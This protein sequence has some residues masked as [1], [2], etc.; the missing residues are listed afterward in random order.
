MRT[1]RI[2][3]QVALAAAVLAA[4]VFGVGSVRTVTPP[5]QGQSLHKELHTFASIT[6]SSPIRVASFNMHSGRGASGKEDLALT[7]KTAQGFDLVGYQEV[8]ASPR[9]T[10]PPQ[11]GFIGQS[12]GQA[13]LFAPTERQYWGDRFGNG[14]TTN[15]PVQ[16]WHREPLPAP[17]EQSR[18]NVLIVRSA[19]PGTTIT[20][21]I[22]HIT[23]SSDQDEQL[24]VVEKL[25]LNQPA[26]AIL[27]GD[28]NATSQ[29]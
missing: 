10:I 3:L 21:L 22:T 24:R 13:W 1:S 12:L 6:R 7:A 20:S 8:Y 19:W 26:P 18:R 16:D 9:P 15:L 11:I 25:F 23:R 29:H 5:A 17:R 2:L 28:L 27:M 4:G 14:L